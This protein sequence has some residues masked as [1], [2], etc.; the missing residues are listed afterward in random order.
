MIFK[1]PIKS[2]NQFNGWFSETANNL[3]ETALDT[4]QP[5]TIYSKII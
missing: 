4:Y 2:R 5:D 1:F 3:F